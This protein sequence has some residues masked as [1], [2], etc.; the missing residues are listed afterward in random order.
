VSYIKDKP[1]R[2]GQL[3]HSYIRARG[4]TQYSL[5]IKCGVPRAYINRIINNSESKPSL[6]ILL[7]I[8]RGL[9]LNNEQKMDLLTSLDY[10]DPGT[11]ADKTLNL[12]ELQLEHLEWASHNFPDNDKVNP[13]LG[14]C[15]EAGE[16]AHAVLKMRQNIRGSEQEHREE[17]EDAIGD[18]C[19]YLLDVCNKYGFNLERVIRKTW[20]EVKQRDWKKNPVNGK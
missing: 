9:G 6:Q 2:F 7:A 10:V 1:T 17:I 5:A 3:L 14:V 18:I 16:L 13:I 20:N 12:Y 11:L 8:I 19:I 15:E 4:M